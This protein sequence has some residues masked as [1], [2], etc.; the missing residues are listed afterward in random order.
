MNVSQ[1]NNLPKAQVLA[2]GIFPDQ[3]GHLEELFLFVGR[4]LGS[5]AMAFMSSIRA[6]R[7]VL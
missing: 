2:I 6:F 4:V 3:F 1:R 7:A 5:F